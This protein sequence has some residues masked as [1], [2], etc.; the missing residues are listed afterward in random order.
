[1]KPSV[2][3][4]TQVA[5]AVVEHAKRFLVGVRPEGK[6]LSGMAEFPGGKVELGETP[7]Q[8][9][10]RECL[11]ESGLRVEITEE[12]FSTEHQYSHGLLEIHF[13][14][15]RLAPESAGAD[16]GM[17]DTTPTAK[18]PFRWIAAE[19]LAT[20]NFPAANAPLTEILLQ[21]SKIAGQNRSR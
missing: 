4:A 16:S 8:A 11:E 19:E 21:S 20:L 13:F 12:Y 6:P 17:G 1:M 10:I 5:I 7:Q 15:C 14:R 9:A 2:E 3:Q 18:S